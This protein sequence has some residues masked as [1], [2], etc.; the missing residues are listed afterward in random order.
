MRVS[1]QLTDARQGVELW[2]QSYDREV[3]DVFAVQDSITQATV[4]QLA[5][6]LGAGSLAATRTGRTTNPDAHDLYLR[7]Q[8]LAMQGSEGALRRAIDL[9]RRSLAKDPAY[10][11]ADAAIAFAYVQLADAFMPSNIAYDSSRA[12][13]RRALASDSLVGDARALRAFASMSLDW[14]FEAGDRELRQA[15]AREPNSA[16]TQILYADYLCSIGR[17][18]EGLTAAK[19]AVAVDP[20][21]PVG[22]WSREHCLYMGR[23]YDQL[24]AEHAQTAASWPDPRFLYWDSFLA[25]AYREKGQFKEAL[26]EY[27]RA[28]QV[29][30][31]VPLFGYAVTLA[32]AGKT[33]EARAMLARLKTYGRDHYVNPITL[34]AVYSALGDRDQAF[35]WLD[36]TTADRT[37]WLWGIRTWPEFDSLQQDP[38]LGQLI[39]RMGL[40]TNT[41]QPR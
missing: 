3:K 2:S 35:A 10:A 9:Y 1:V 37:G 8:T 39:K 24:I 4:K 20:L 7:G 16:L 23:H 32:R 11:Q 29:A 38:R 21:N 26:A 12:A 18:E 15:A 6:S 34:A 19:T 14:S 31:E 41:Q 22:P 13:A 28:Q 17:T 30:G 33:A 5:L 36:R 25:A 40:P 27:E